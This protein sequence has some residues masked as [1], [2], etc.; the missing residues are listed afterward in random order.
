VAVRTLVNLG[1]VLDAFPA[2]GSIP[3]MP[4]LHRRPAVVAD[5]VWIAELR[6]DVLHESL[7]RLG[8]YDPQRVRAR[9]LDGFRVAGTSVVELGGQPVGCLALRP[10]PGATWLE[11][12]YLAPTVQ[13][14]GVGA[15]L[16]TLLTAR[17]DTLGEVLRLTVLRLSAAQRLYARH[18]FIV[19]DA[20]D[21]DVYMSRRPGP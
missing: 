21:V 16:L 13:G 5:A 11:H 8:R 3:G 9:F 15:A 20:D 2:D 14:R 10:E 17:A 7:D 19:D 12:F 4:G 6:A 18:G 1:G